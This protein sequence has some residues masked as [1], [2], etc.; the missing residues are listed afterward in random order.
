M[1]NRPGI[2]AIR[3]PSAIEG[4]RITIEGS[5]FPVDDGPQLPTVT[6]GGERAR[7]VYASPTAIGVV[8]PTVADGGRATVRIDG[9]PGDEAYVDV[10]STLATGL[11]Q[12][13]N[14]VFDRAGNLYVTYSGTRGQ[15]VPVSIFRVRPNGMRETFSSGIVNPTSMAIDPEGRLYVSSRFEGTVYRVG[16]DGSSESFASDLGVACGLAFASD[17]TLF[18][19]DRS[20]TIFRVDREGH[21]QAFAS[22]PPSVAAF[23]LA[24]A[25]DGALHVTAPTLS[26]YDGIYRIDSSGEV[27]QP[28]TGFGRPQGLAFDPSGALFVVEAL[29]GSS[30]LYRIPADGSPALVLSG[31]GLIGVAFDPGGGLVVCSNETAY[32]VSRSA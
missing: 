6:V 8:V 13:D 22:L 28:Y 29:A 12:V 19:G 2:T 25:P 7:V 17:G 23:H 11:H 32:R 4:G 16:P 27:S 14:P 9:V 10:A 31:P 5:G 1:S 3:P 26:S 18:V 15:E 21:A 24:L 30:G 20:G